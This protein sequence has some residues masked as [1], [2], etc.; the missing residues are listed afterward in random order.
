MSVEGDVHTLITRRYR[1]SLYAKIRY[2]V[3]YSS[4]ASK[5]KQPILTNKQQTLTP[6][7]TE[8]HRTRLEAPACSPL[9]LRE[10]E[11][12][13]T[14]PP[15]LHAPPATM[16]HRTRLEALVRSIQWLRDLNP[17]QCLLTPPPT[18]R[19]L[20]TPLIPVPVQALIPATTLR[21]RT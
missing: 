14:L 15:T 18:V 12:L 1:P 13:P 16:A 6:P 2:V 10:T 7:A 20:L 4:N 8:P 17:P 9:R 11:V 3:L 5:S 19:A 21:S